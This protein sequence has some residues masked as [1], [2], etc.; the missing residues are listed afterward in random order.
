LSEADAR[1]EELASGNDDSV[2]KFVQEM[3]LLRT[4]QAK[5]QEL[6]KEKEQA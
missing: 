3:E 2:I 4:Q 1:Y 6:W 5:A